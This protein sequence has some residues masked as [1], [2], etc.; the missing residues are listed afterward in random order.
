MGDTNDCYRI[1]GNYPFL[2]C[3]SNRLA[4]PEFYVFLLRE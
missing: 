4:T 2:T 1:N 3:A